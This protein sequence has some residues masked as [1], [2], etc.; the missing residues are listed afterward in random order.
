[1]QA[2][3]R[4]IHFGTPAFEPALRGAARASLTALEAKGRKL[5]ILEPL[6]LA[7]GVLNPMTCLSKAT[8]LD[9]CR[10]VTIA[11]TPIKKYYRTLANGTNIF[12]LDLD[13]LV[14]PYLPICDPIVRG[15]VV[16]R[17]FQH[18]TAGYSKTLAT[19]IGQLL[20]ADGIIPRPR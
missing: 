6:P 9:E 4:L 13:R 16:K 18:I 14:C 11:A 7:P 20:T 1:M 12:T 10:Y 5:V 8:Y 2:N 3:G 19:P 17:D 15:V